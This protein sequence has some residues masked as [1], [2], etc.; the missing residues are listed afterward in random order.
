MRR[1]VLVLVAMAAAMVAGPPT[2]SEARS[3]L[4]C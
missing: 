4:G 2:V 3:L 1:R